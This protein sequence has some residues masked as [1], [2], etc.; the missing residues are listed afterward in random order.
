MLP[1]P[2]VT[3]RPPTGGR[4]MNRRTFLATAALT[5]GRAAADS[6]GRL[7]QYGGLRAVRSEASGFFRVEKRDRWWL[8]TPAGHGWLGFGV[9]HV[10][11]GWL[12]QPYNAS[13]WLK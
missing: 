7:D 6:P 13:A 5:G 8:V 10:T 2:G 1:E 9:N 11:P 3:G 12:N 4:G